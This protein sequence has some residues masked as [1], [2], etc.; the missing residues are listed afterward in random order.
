M[1]YRDALLL[2]MLNNSFFHFQKIA[3]TILCI[4]FFLPIHQNLSLSVE[5]NCLL[6]YSTK[7]T[8]RDNVKPFVCK[9]TKL[10][11]IL[12]FFSFVI[13][14]L[15][16]T[17]ISGILWFFSHFFVFGQSFE[18]YVT[19]LKRQKDKKSKSKATIYIY[20]LYIYIYII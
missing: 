18:T 9:E 6:L 20:V 10:T 17:S 16:R 4:P 5:F 1:S 2:K 14:F 8:W 13:L 11:F 19:L 3:V 7:L 15:R 12:L